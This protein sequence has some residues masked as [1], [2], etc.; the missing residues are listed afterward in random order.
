MEP[1]TR[2]ER[3][4]LAR[5]ARLASVGL[6]GAPHLVPCCHVLLGDVVYTA[7]DDVK[8]KG[9]LRLRRLENLRAEAR[10]AV[11]VDHYDDDWS[12]LWWVRVDG[13]ARLLDE[14]DERERALDALGEKYEQYRTARPPGTVIALDI[15]R[16]SA[17]P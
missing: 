9:S 10:A 11:L 5:V 16:W 2:R 14:G 7:V 8:A 17:W 3:L 1:V 13:S 6:D 4:A 15:A 12:T